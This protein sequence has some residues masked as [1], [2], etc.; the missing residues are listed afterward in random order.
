[1][2]LWKQDKG[3]TPCSAAFLESIEKGTEAPITAR[4]L[5]EVAK[6]TIEIAEQLR[7]Q[8]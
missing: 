7:N 6:V 5:F 1:M 4:E 8:R 2:N 3:Q